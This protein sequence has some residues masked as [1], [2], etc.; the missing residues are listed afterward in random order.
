[1][2]THTPSLKTSAELMEFLQI[3]PNT[4][5]RLALPTIRVGRQRRYD[6]EKVLEQLSG[7]AGA[8]VAANE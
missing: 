3:S 6:L 7:S 4:L 2:K 8:E 1:M 5:K